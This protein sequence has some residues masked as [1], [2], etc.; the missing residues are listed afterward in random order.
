[1]PK[2]VYSGQ[3]LMKLVNTN[4]MASTS[5]PIPKVPVSTPVK[6]SKAIAIAAQMR[7][8]RSVEPMFGFIRTAFRWRKGRVGIIR[9]R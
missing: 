4:T 1:M 8:T 3:K 9:D 2:N 5:S 6:Y 7:I